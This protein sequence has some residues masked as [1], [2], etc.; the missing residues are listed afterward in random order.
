MANRKNSWTNVALVD[1]SL[2]GAY[3]RFINVFKIGYIAA[4][5][6]TEGPSARDLKVRYSTGKKSCKNKKKLEK[7]MKV[8]VVRL[9][10]YAAPNFS[11]VFH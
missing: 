4:F 2:L 1:L 10:W 6:Q 5:I 3:V 7:A 9:V 11:F 8:L